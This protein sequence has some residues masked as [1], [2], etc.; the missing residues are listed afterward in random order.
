MCNMRSCLT[1]PEN[2]FGSSAL[3]RTGRAGEREFLVVSAHAPPGL[4]Q[5]FTAPNLPISC[6][7]QPVH[8]ALRGEW[9]LPPRNGISF[10][11]LAR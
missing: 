11:N 9:P 1:T 8:E 4:T 7:T 2:A 5:K 6:P 10:E 3:D